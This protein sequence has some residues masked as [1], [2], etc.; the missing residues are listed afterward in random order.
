M[1]IG[2]YNTLTAIRATIHGFYLEDEE[3]QEVLLPNKHV[4]ETLKPNDRIEV[5]IY[6]DSEDRLTATVLKP[7]ITLHQFAGLE[8]TAVTKF[9][10]FLDWGLEKDLL[11]PF[12]EQR[13]RMEVGKRYVVYLLL[14]EKTDR[15]VATNHIKRYIEPEPETT[16]GEAVDLL[17]AD[18]TDLGYNVIINSQYIG[19]LYYNEIFQEI[20]TGDSLKGYIKNIRED[21]KVDVSLQQQGYKNIAPNSQKILTVLK[22]HNGFL[23]LTDKSS[24]VDIIDLLGMSKKTFKKAIGNLYKQRLIELKPNGIQLVNTK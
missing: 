7:K 21:G 12:K 20:K 4:P 6:N 10:A 1:K 22:E 14:D 3:G 15:L 16:V 8:V 2:E 24:P 5:F 9:G 17:V 23:P 13:E 18:S 19:L 11:V